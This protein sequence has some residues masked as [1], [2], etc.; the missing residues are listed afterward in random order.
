MGIAA[1]PGELPRDWDFLDDL[2]D[3][4][5]FLESVEVLVV[6]RCGEW[7][8]DGIIR[9]DDDGRGSTSAS[10]PGWDTVCRDVVVLVCCGETA[11]GVGVPATWSTRA[12][13]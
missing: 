13:S 5:D 12:I 6:L 3:L 7:V 8:P 9:D 4:M 1:F 11:C 10:G 2:V